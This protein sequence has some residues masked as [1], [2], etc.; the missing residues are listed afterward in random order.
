MSPENLKLDQKGQI[1]IK[2]KCGN[3]FPIQK[4]MSGFKINRQVVWAVFDCDRVQG[5]GGAAGSELDTQ[6]FDEEDKD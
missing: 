4:A 5:M 6:E 1:E 3:F 2:M